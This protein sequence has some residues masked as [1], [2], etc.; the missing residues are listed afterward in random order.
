MGDIRMNMV[1]ARGSATESAVRLRPSSSDTASA[2]A[3]SPWFAAI[4]SRTQNRTSSSSCSCVVA[5]SRRT[6]GRPQPVADQLGR[7]CAGAAVAQD[8][9]IAQRLDHG[10]LPVMVR[11]GAETVPVHNTPPEKLCPTAQ[12]AEAMTRR[13]GF[14]EAGTSAAEGLTSMPVCVHL[15][16]EPVYFPEIRA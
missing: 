9:G 16:P 5:C 11:A 1:R 4:S 2:S 14:C 6:T 10:L 12:G 13:Q 15:A 3:D 8:R 7:H